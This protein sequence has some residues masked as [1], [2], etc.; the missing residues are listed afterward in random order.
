MYELENTL[1]YHKNNLFLNFNRSP[2][3]YN[4][5]VKDN[6]IIRVFARQIMKNQV[7]EIFPDILCLS[8]CH[9]FECSITTHEPLDRFAFASKFDLESR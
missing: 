7:Y 6:L 4:F 2:L 5:D 1:H 8:V 3:Y 9:L